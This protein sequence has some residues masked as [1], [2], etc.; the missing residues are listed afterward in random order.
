MN[1]NSQHA[2]D[3][4]TATSEET[5]EESTTST[6]PGGWGPSDFRGWGVAPM[7]ERGRETHISRSTA[8]RNLRADFVHANLTFTGNHQRDTALDSLDTKLWASVQSYRSSDEARKGSSPFP[9][10]TG[11]QVLQRLE[12]VNALIASRTL[13]HQSLK[14]DILEVSNTLS[15]LRAREKQASTEIKALRNAQRELE[16]LKEIAHA[17][18]S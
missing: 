4:E 16:D 15:E 2:D 12:E 14:N 8:L 5:M 17:R 13:E 10:F 18:L 7:N 3:D 1:H 6:S 11:P 9:T